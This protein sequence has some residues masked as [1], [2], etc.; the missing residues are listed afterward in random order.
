MAGPGD[1]TSRQ[2]T[3]IID[4]DSFSTLED[5]FKQYEERQKKANELMKK[6]FL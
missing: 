3:T 2:K 5:F 1:I 4:E 6:G